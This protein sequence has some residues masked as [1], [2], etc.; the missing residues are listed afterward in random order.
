[1]AK[2]PL[3]AVRAELNDD[4]DDDDVR[5]TAVFHT[6]FACLHRRCDLHRTSSLCRN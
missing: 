2:A 5:M 4:D 1:M 3:A 6:P